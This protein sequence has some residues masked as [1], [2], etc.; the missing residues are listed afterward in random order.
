MLL[1][2]TR[3]PLP[4]YLLQLLQKFKT[5]GTKSGTF[6]L[7]LESVACFKYVFTRPIP[8]ARELIYSF[9]GIAIRQQNHTAKGKVKFSLMQNGLY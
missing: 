8:F 7:T 4:L 2:M 3:L 1:L 9:V 6:E 5:F